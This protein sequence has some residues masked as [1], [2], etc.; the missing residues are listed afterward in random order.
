MKF[1]S[2]RFKLKGFRV[3]LFEIKFLKESN[4]WMLRNVIYHFFNF[5]SIRVSFVSFV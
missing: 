2:F 3:R 4:I 1:F 5:S